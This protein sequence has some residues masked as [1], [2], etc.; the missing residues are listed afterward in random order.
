MNNERQLA[1][2][3][4]FDKTLSKLSRVRMFSSP[5]AKIE[6][7]SKLVNTLMADDGQQE[8]D[9][10]VYLMVY[11][12]ICIGKRSADLLI[13]IKYIKAFSIDDLYGK[14][15][16]C[17]C[18]AHIESALEMLKTGLEQHFGEQ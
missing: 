13:E 15:D 3:E 16:S 12:L 1:C 14:H 8:A 17:Q 18:L 5:T 4:I 9:S 10:V 7:I 6:F 2:K 11:S